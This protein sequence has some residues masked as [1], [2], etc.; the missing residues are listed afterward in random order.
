MYKD[1]SKSRDK[2]QCP[3]KTIFYQNKN[4]HYPCVVYVSLEAYIIICLCFH[5]EFKFYNLQYNTIY[6]NN[7]NTFCFSLS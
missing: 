1:I 6:D 5:L 7:Y 4:D 3:E 2:S